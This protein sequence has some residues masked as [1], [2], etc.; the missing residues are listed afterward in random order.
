MPTLA[1]GTTNTAPGTTVLHFKGSRM[2]ILHKGMSTTN[3]DELVC[4]IHLEDGA[5]WMRP[6]SEFDDIVMWP[7]GVKRTRFIVADS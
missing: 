2:K 4:Y 6:A 1:P 3:G 5:I 7:D